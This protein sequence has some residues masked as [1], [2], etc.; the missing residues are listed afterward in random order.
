MGLAALPN[1]QFDFRN[2]KIKSK[3]IIYS[4]AHEKVGYM[5]QEILYIC[6]RAGIK[7]L[8]CNLFKMLNIN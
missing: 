8:I 3:S 5:L 2:E 7:W 4:Q 1:L 6:F